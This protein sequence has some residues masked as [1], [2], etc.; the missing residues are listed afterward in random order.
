MASN[1]E[2]RVPALRWCRALVAALVAE[3]V[4][5]IVAAGLYGFA[6][7]PSHLLN[8]VTPP[9][10]F[11]VFIPA[12]YWT[13]RAALPGT[14]LINGATPGLWGV[15]LYIALGLVA[16]QFVEGTS[17]TDGFTPAYLA[18]HALKIIGGML[19]GWLA[20]RRA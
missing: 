10:A 13:A 20:A 14:Q 1:P 7:D 8:L 19:G 3:L 12:G 18:A 15:V 4:L 11:I 2:A 17:V 5:M 6:A 16:S 9:A